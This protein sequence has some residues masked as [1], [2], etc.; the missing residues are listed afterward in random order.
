MQQ[1]RGTHPVAANLR[2]PKKEGSVLKTKV[3]AKQL[4][5]LQRLREQVQKA[6]AARAFR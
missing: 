1:K 3:L 4:F 5:E 6:E 2:R